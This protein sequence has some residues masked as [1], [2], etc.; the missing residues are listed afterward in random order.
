MTIS[1][2][3]AFE[4]FHKGMHTRLQFG[5]GELRADR[6]QAEALAGLEPEQRTELQIHWDDCLECIQDLVLFV[7]L[8]REALQR[9]PLTVTPKY[10]VSEILNSIQDRQHVSSKILAPLRV[11][12]LVALLLGGVLALSWIINTVRPRPSGS[13]IPSS[14]I[15]PTRTPQPAPTQTESQPAFNKTPVEPL[16]L[17]GLFEMNHWSPDGRYLQII[18]VDPSPDQS[19][20]RVYSS[21]HFLDAQSGQVCQSGEPL[22]GTQFEQ[23]SL[24]WLPDGKVLVASQDDMSIYTPCSPQVEDI[25]ALFTDQIQNVRKPHLSSDYLV[26]T[27]QQSFWIFEPVS[28]DVRQLDGLAP[29]RSGRDHIFSSPSGEAIAISQAVETGSLISLVDLQNGQ[30]LEQIN[31]PLGTEQFAAWLDWLLED[32]ILVYGGPNLGSVLVERQPNNSARLTPV[33]EDLFGLDSLSLGEITA[34]G[35]YRDPQRGIYYLTLAT[36]SP[37]ERA[38]YIYHSDGS[39]VEEIPH[40]LDTFLFFPTGEA[41]N[42]HRLEDTPSFSNLLQL[43]WVDHPTRGSQQLTVQGHTPRQYPQVTHAWD[44]TTQRMAFGSTQGVS[45]VSMDDGQL[46]EFW[47]LDGALD[48]GYTNLSLSPDGITLAVQALLD[49]ATKVG[50]PESA[51]YIITL[52]P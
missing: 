37:E 3:K 43:V 5:A 9:W 6:L 44:P 20:D 4:L 30:I 49:N 7:S 41:V 38:L 26:L 1:H 33:V 24:N 11:V 46:I 14:T 47:S 27:G 25:S 23:D 12:L 16:I 52:P 31:V 15:Q 21:L 17:G 51:F 19:S 32:V 36:R 42:M 39:R 8:R 2:R 34:Q 22:L 29:S 10:S 28:R 13:A 50:Q 48:S 40:D 45:L 18:R 35:G